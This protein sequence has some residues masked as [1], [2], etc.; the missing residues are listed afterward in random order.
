MF[1]PRPHGAPNKVKD[2]GNV[3]GAVVTSLVPVLKYSYLEYNL[4]VA[5]ASAGAHVVAARQVII[6]A[7]A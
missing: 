4:A 6:D 3:T 2:I 1:V 7:T 5:N